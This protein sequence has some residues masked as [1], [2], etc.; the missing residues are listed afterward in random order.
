M[1]GR[2]FEKFDHPPAMAGDRRHVV[3]SEKNA[4]Q[5]GAAVEHRAAGITAF[6]RNTD[7]DQFRFGGIGFRGLKRKATAAANS[8]G[9]VPAVTGDPIIV[10][11]PGN[12]RRNGYRL[13]AFRF[14]D[15]E[16]CQVPA[17]IDGNH[18]GVEFPLVGKSHLDTTV[19]VANDVPIRHDETVIRLFGDER[20]RSVRYDLTMLCD[21]SHDRRM[22]LPGLGLLCP[23]IPGNHGDTD[24]EQ[25]K[26]RRRKAKPT[27]IR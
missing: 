19:R 16:Q 15:D 4:G 26:Q 8:I 2:L 25:E 10:A 9:S 1:R 20:P 3:R 18:G 22:R 14:G 27:E 23:R 5:F 24:R 7:V 17:I 21:D 11:F 12:G 13:D 6:G